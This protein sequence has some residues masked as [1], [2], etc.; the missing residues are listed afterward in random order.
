MTEDTEAAAD[1]PVP[2]SW[3]CEEA[4]L[5]CAEALLSNEAAFE[6]IEA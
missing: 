2:G 1:V 6:M 5:S 4:A 3:T